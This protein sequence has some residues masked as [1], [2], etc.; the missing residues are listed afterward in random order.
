MEQGREFDTSGS[1]ISFL[2]VHITSESHSPVLFNALFP[3]QVG[4]RF[5]Q[6]VSCV[7]IE[8]D[9]SCIVQQIVQVVDISPECGV[10]GVITLVNYRGKNTISETL[11][12]S[13]VLQ[14]RGQYT[15]DRKSR[16]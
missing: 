8:K 13:P 2:A 16:R 10:V 11:A 1:N 15:P 7:N 5:V 14:Y 12:L 6:G 4:T 9:P 3:A